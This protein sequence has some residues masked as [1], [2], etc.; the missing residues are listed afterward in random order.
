MRAAALATLALLRLH[1][2]AAPPPAPTIAIAP[3]VELPLVSLGTAEYDGAELLNITRSA[4][5]MG[6]VGI[7]NDD[8]G[9][10]TDM[11]VALR[12]I[13]RS[14]FFL[15]AKVNGGQTKAETAAEL[16][17]E[18][19][20]LGVGA[21]DLIL[22][23]HPTPA[24]GLSLNE[25]IQGQWAAVEEFYR[26]G[27]ARSIGVS[28]FCPMAFAALF[29]TA[30]ITP[31]V[32]Q[33]M[34]HAGMG[35]DPDSVRTFALTHKPR[36]LPMAYSALDQASSAILRGPVYA[37][38]AAR[39]KVTPAQ[40]ALRWVTQHTPPVPLVVAASDPIYLEQNLDIFH[41]SLTPEEMAQIS[42][43]KSCHA[44]S[45]HD[46]YPCLPYWPGGACNPCCCKAPPM[47]V[48]CCCANASQ[49]V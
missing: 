34:L 12:G 37:E 22:L 41:F 17:R 10:G 39:H 21:I 23:H 43:E 7:D 27:R 44:G 3:G 31:A 19:A 48:G 33:I 18:H 24:P 4:L 26:S 45:D 35:D 9:R 47:H 30:L 49:P 1:R 13:A 29:E 38:I 25:T 28:N 16:E 6:Y 11:G 40:V 46:H 42:A 36:I 20:A 5:A 15:T 2:A 14:R 8:G 32:N